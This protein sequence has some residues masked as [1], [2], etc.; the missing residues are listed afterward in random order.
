MSHNGTLNRKRRER[1]PVQLSFEGCEVLTKQSFQN[2][3]DINAIMDRW[4]RTGVIDHFAANPPTFG[5]FNCEQDFQDAQNSIIQANEAFDALPA[6]VRDRMQN[7]P[8]KL[9]TFLND[10]ANDDEA[11]SLGLLPQIPAQPNSDGP[12]TQG[13]TASPGGEAPN[14]PSPAEEKTPQV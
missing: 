12:G 10:P 2:E 5:D 9:L 7:D 1:I 11:R 8:G 14:G 13:A 3:C 4:T 6:K